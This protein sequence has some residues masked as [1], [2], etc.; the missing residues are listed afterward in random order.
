MEI[1]LMSL[2]FLIPLGVY[3]LMRPRRSDRL[4]QVR[5]GIALFATAITWA[6]CVS[7]YREGG[8]PVLMAILGAVFAGIAVRLLIKNRTRIPSDGHVVDPG[9]R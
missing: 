9:G 1:G 5:A 7:Q 3:I 8:T 4:A 2:A 6:G